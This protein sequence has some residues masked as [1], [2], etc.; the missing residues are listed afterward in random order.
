MPSNTVPW[1]MRVCGR[2]EP[3][4]AIDSPFCASV[5]EGTEEATQEYFS[6]VLPPSSNAIFD[7]ARALLGASVVYRSDLELLFDAS[8]AATAELHVEGRNFY[9]PMLHD[10]ASA[11]ST[12]HVNQFGFRPGVV[13]EAFAEA[14]LAKAAEGVQ[15]RLVVDSKG[16]DPDG[17]SREFYDRLVRGGVDVR[18][19]RATQPRAPTQPVAAGGAA[20]W[21]FGHLAHID[22]RKVVVVDGSI[23]W[24]GGAGVEDHFQDGRFHDLFLRVTGPVVSQ[25]QLVFVATFRWL[26][27]GIAVVA[28]DASL[29]APAA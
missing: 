18:V 13:G 22:H 7:R 23:G 1:P 15:V 9:P 19:V 4:I 2:S 11:R 25:L 14:L 24:V 28:A 8:V 21:N 3:L 20:R 17:S 12:V 29:P 10:I 5:G 16:S 27:G 6:S 26:G